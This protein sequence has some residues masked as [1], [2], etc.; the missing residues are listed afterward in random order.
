MTKKKEDLQQ[1]TLRFSRRFIKDL[2]IVAI[3]KGVT[4]A[5]LIEAMVDAPLQNLKKE[6]I[7]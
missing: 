5:E 1:I 7:K 4:P 2:K 6:N 3:E